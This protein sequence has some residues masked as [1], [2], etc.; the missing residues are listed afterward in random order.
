ME[1]LQASV[2]D[3]S[4]ALEFL[5]Q[6]TTPVF[7][8]QNCY[9]QQG[10]LMYKGRIYVGVKGRWRENVLNK[11]HNFVQGGHSGI[12]NTYARVSQL[13]FWPKMRRDIKRFVQECDTCQ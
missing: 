2:A 8:P 3:D 4:E 11:L 6:A 10:V 12:E 7:G 5:L 13:L 9:F 1:E